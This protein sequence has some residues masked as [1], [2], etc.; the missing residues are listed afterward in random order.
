MFSPQSRGGRR[1]RIFIRIPERGILIKLSVIKNQ[2][3][4]FAGMAY[5]IV[6]SSLSEENTINKNLAFSAS[7]VSEANGR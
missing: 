2:S 4:A 6:F 5:S 3:V 1:E 7:Q